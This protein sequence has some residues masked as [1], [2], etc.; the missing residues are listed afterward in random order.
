MSYWV[1]VRIKWSKTYKTA[2]TGLGWNSVVDS[3]LNIHE[4]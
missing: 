4:P 3:L 2:V 1:S